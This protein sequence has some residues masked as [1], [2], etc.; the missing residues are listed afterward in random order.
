[1]IAVANVTESFRYFSILSQSRE[2]AKNQSD[3]TLRLCDFAREKNKN[4][5]ETKIK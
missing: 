1:M 3:Y 2:V 4:Y 5:A